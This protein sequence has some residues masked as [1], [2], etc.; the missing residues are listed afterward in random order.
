MNYVLDCG[1]SGCRFYRKGG[2]GESYIVALEPK[3]HPPL[4]E[5]LLH[6]KKHVP[7]FV[8]RFRSKVRNSSYSSS[9]QVFFVITAGA[10]SNLHHLPKKSLQEFLSLMYDEYHFRIVYPKT[11][12]TT[13]EL[14]SQLKY[15][16]VNALLHLCRISD[17]VCDG[18]IGIGGASIQI[19]YNKGDNH[20]LLPF[21]F[22][23]PNVLE[24]P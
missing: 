8:R 23:T 15:R 24:L 17:R 13:A 5:V 16:A 18:H 14:E 6:Q 12:F 10:R 2:K 9:Y 4:H 1:S 3:F 22:M 19:S 20:V 7:A 11:F 21:S